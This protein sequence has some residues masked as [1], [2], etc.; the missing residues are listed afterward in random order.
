MKVK[1]VEESGVLLLVKM[2]PKSIELGFVTV[3]DKSGHENLY[4]LQAFKIC[5]PDYNYDFFTHNVTS[6]HLN[7]EPKRKKFWGLF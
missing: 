1:L 3:K 5:Y 7:D 4:L 2:A 6:K